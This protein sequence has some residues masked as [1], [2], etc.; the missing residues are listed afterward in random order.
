MWENITPG[1]ESNFNTYGPD[2][3]TNFD[4][5]YDVTSVMH[6]SAYAGSKNGLAT[7]VPHVSSN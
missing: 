7:I 6:Y 5:E 3:I 4:I 2:R 1:T